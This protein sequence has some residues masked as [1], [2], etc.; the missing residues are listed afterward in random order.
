VPA[1][2]APPP[3]APPAPQGLDGARRALA[4]GDWREAARL[5]GALEADAGAA[6][7]AVRALA[8][9]DPVA[10]VRACAEAAARH[11]LAE[12]LRYLESLL[13]LG[14]GRLAESERAARQALYLEPSL[15][16]AWLTLG[17]VLRRLGDTEGAVRAFRSAEL[18]CAALPEDAPV[19]LAD[20]ERA[21]TLAQV[22]RA[23]RERLEEARA[24]E[25]L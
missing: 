10:A 23:E 9:L 24:H 8:N 11:P 2:V 14:Q 21:G 20:G 25:E 12:E 1:F 3:P 6:A 22:A 13:L 4:R 7:M 19:P 16:V 18:L 15:A 17:N 5:A